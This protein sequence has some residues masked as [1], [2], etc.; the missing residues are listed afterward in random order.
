MLL[1]TE[2][3]EVHTSTEYAGLGQD[4]DT[5]DPVQLHFHIWVAVG[6]AK[7]CKV[8]SPCSVLSVSFHNDGILV[9]AI[10]KRQCSLRFLPGVQIVRLL[11]T[12]PIWKRSPNIYRRQLV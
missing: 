12:K 11:S 9:Q 5:A 4:T 7:V 1:E 8:R 2:G 3:W 10:R 6:I